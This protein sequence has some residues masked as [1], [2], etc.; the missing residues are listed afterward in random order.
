MNDIWS[1]SKLSSY[2]N[3]A[4]AWYLTY[5]LHE[6]GDDNVYGVLGN[7]I[8][9]CLESMCK[10][11]MTIEEAKEK[12]KQDYDMCKFLGMNFPTENTE[13]KYIYDIEHAFD[14]FEKPKGRLEE[15]RYIEFEIENKKFRGYVDLIIFDDEKKTIQVLDWKSS[16]KFSKKDLESHKVFQLIL[17]SMYLEKEY[18]DYKILNPVFYMLKYAR[19][20][21]DVTGRESIRERIDIDDTIHEVL[22]PYIVEVKYNDDMKDKLKQ[23]INE[24]TLDIAFNDEDE[25]SDWYPTVE[26]LRNNSFYCKNLCGH[27]KSCKFYKG[28]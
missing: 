17:Y 22:E 13:K 8:H 10:D 12:F 11:E 15:E 19:V 27:K 5:V 7:S 25:E 26:E 18:P 6:K 21:N 14:Y 23:Y 4:Y 16:S 28:E 20:K 9:D 3:C 24:V 1:F 2:H